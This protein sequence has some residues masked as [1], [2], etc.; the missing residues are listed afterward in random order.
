VVVPTAERAARHSMA[1]AP[2]EA[3]LAHTGRMNLAH[4][5]Q[6]DHEHIGQADHLVEVRTRCQT[7]HTDPCLHRATSNHLVDESGPKR[8]LERGAKRWPWES[9]GIS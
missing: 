5:G 2:I 3:D 8:S 9:G 4:R 6:V 7:Q 1:V